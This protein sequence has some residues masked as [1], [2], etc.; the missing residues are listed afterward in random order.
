[1][2]SPA[3]DLPLHNFYWVVHGRLLAGEYPGGSSDRETRSRINALRDL[4]IDCFIDLTRPGEREPY[5]A[6]LPRE[7]EYQRKPVGD[8]GIPGQAA[9]MAEILETI[10]D[11][12]GRNRRVYLHCRAGIGRTGM[13]AGC[14]LV[15]SGMS[16]ANALDELNR[17]W[18]Q[19]PRSASWDYVP[20]T[21]EQC[22]YVR[23]WAGMR[24]VLLEGATLQAASR[25]RDRFH[26]ALVGLAVADALAAATQFRAPGGF[27]P[28]GDMIGGGPFDLPAGAW[29]DDTAMALCVAESLLEC[30]G[31]DT[32]DQIE[33][34]TRWQRE[35]YLSATGQCVGITSGV[36]RAL[37]AAK[38]RQRRFT[39]SFDPTQLDREPMSRLAP[40]VMFCLASAD[41]AMRMAENATRLTCQAPLVLDA[42][43]LVG[44]MLHAALSGAGKT[45]ILA[46][47]PRLFQPAL[48]PELAEL[49]A[50]GFRSFDG[51]RGRGPQTLLEVLAAALLAFERSANYRQGALE[52][53][54]LGGESDIAGAIYG[55]LAGAH[56]GIRAVP[57]A[58]RA[59]LKR[60]EMIEEF[61]D[62]LLALAMLGLA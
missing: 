41:D 43:R 54:N 3:L 25:L 59:G 49:A 24:D 52:V 23:N 35:G 38:W 47:D 31:F 55:Q 57:A 5:N 11:A 28:V 10:E 14:H 56:W 61:C 34:L 13:V 8:H 39:G 19:S 12:L 46:P 37:A 33:R 29:S 22:D 32:A 17:L 53:I 4:G 1:M 9:E 2:S 51:A 58:W 40:A 26:G 20:E 16:G 18:R 48:K 60:I 27:A 15:E 50:G 36:A 62:R 44:A 7:V 21:R 45:R 6:F 42:A 30:N